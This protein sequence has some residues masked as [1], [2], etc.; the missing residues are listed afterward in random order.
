M[1]PPKFVKSED[2][3]SLTNLNEAS[4]LFNLKDRYLADLI[5]V[6]YET[7]HFPPQIYIYK[8]EKAVLL[9]LF[10]IFIKSTMLTHPVFLLQTYSGLFC[11]VINPYKEL[12][13][14]SEDV[15]REFK[16]RKRETLPPHV[17]AIAD[18]A[19][20]SMIEVRNW[21]SGEEPLFLLP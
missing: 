19:Y 8:G 18:E 11:V 6:R 12:P 16:G 15:I 3:A 17:Y 2:M 10:L 1:N 13:I 20:R 9:F 14:Y 7:L 21:R 4:V 5:Y